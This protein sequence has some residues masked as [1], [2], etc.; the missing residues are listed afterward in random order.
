MTL[1]TLN[2]VNTNDSYGRP[3]LQN[4]DGINRTNANDREERSILQNQDGGQY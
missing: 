3:I 1:M 4:Q 2:M